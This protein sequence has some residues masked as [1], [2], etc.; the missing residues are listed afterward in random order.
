M[1][2]RSKPFTILMADDD[3]DDCMLVRDALDELQLPHQ[4]YFVRDG[5]ELADYLQRRGDYGDG[6]NAPCP[7]LIL[8]D[9][10]MPKRDGREA[11]Q[12]LKSDPQLRRIPIVALTT[13]TA[14]DDVQF[15]YDMGVNSYVTKPVTFRDLVAMMSILCTYWFELVELPR[16][17]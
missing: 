7:D 1:A 8:L 9:M 6:R 10:K 17:E 13:S 2:K 16:L 5:E 12:Q 4:L 3:A 14:A 11:I 15:S